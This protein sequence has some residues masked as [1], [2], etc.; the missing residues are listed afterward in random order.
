MEVDWMIEPPCVP[1]QKNFAD[2]LDSQLFKRPG[3]WG[4]AGN[5]TT[6]R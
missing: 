1:H 4:S 5:A 3:A 6:I 2:E